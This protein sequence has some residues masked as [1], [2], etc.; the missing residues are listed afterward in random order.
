MKRK[1]IVVE[2]WQKWKFL[3]QK[4]KIPPPHKI[5]TRSMNV[6]VFDEKLKEFLEENE[7][8]YSVVFLTP[9]T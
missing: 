7:I 2:D 4:G 8:K 5:A 9:H 6:F 3:I 1:M